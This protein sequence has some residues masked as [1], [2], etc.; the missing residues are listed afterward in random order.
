VWR[1]RLDWLRASHPLLDGWDRGSDNRNPG[2]TAR[3]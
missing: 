2:S 3:E 1:G